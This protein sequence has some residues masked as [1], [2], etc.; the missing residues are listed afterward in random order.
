MPAP[1]RG[2]WGESGNG[3]RSVVE[4]R[5][6]QEDPAGRGWGAGVILPVEILRR[7]TRRAWNFKAARPCSQW[8]IFGA[9]PLIN[10]IC[11]RGGIADVPT[12][13]RRKALAA[14]L[15][16]FHARLDD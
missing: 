7:P 8:G 10:R 2:R 15:A 14:A 4:S 5:S 12:Q 3:N 9:G 16:T 6:E 11:W 1:K 13:E